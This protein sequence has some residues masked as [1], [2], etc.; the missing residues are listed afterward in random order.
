MYLLEMIGRGLARYLVA[1][2]KREARP[3]TCKPELL[4]ST[5]CKGDVILV[6]GSNRV[7]TAN[8]ILV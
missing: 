2:S 3:A 8:N 4:A 7:S 6:E 1:P 5:L